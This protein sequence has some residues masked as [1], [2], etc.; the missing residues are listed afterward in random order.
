[1]TLVLMIVISYIFS[2]GLEIYANLKFNKILAD[3]N[4]LMT[5]GR[6]KLGETDIFDFIPYA[7]MFKTFFNGM[8]LLSNPEVAQQLY[9]SGI[10]REMTELEQNI[11]NAKPSILRAFAT[12]ILAEEMISESREVVI[13]NY[14]GD[15][16]VNYLI[17]RE[18]EEEYRI[19]NKTGPSRTVSDEVIHT[20]IMEAIM[21][22]QKEALKITLQDAE[23]QKQWTGTYYEVLEKVGG[24]DL[25]YETYLYLNVLN[26][27][28]SKYIDSKFNALSAEEKLEIIATK[29]SAYLVFSKKAS[30]GLPLDTQVSL[31]MSTFID[32]I[33]TLSEAE[34][35]MNLAMPT[36]VETV[37]VTKEEL[38]KLRDSLVPEIGEKIDNYQKIKTC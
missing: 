23:M 5:V 25:A 34:F 15:V 37:E 21:N 27:A 35:V 16:A 12:P 1:M 17:L 24:Q 26:E 32:E 3:Q 14:Y 4:Y 20:H 38:L 7:N 36:N 31:S 29:L 13:D 10:I 22:L 8:E 18:E 19:I 6:L 30:F 9:D 33:A 2:Q 11:Y 28:E